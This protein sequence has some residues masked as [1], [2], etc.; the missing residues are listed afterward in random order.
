MI[1]YILKSV[2][3]RS[4]QKESIVAYGKR[5]PWLRLLFP[6]LA[7]KT[8]PFDPKSSCHKVRIFRREISYIEAVKDSEFYAKIEDDKKRRD[9]QKRLQDE[10]KAKA[11]AEAK[12]N[13]NKP[14]DTLPE[15]VRAIP[16][17]KKKV[18]MGTVK[19]FDT[20]EKP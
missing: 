5:A 8:F 11:A 3:Q 17:G 16:S 2:D 1:L 15:P 14:P 4:G 20:G 10:A 13:A 18:T 6:W 12:L 9:E 19:H 7:V